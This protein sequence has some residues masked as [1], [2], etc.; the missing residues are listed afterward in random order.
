MAMLSSVQKQS[1]EATH[2]LV[3]TTLTVEVQAASHV[4]KDITERAQ[5]SHV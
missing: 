4:K 1:Q 3:W 2:V 5:I